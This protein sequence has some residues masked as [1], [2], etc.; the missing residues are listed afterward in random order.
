MTEKIFKKSNLILAG[1]GFGLIILGFYLLG[2]EPVDGLSSLTV[3]PIILT[4]AFVLV[5]PMG[6]LIGGK[7]KE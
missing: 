4:L 2:A 5:I 7:E 3:A 6:L 1:L